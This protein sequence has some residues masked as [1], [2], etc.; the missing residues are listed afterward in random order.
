MLREAF[1]FTL[2]SSRGTTTNSESTESDSESSKGQLHNAAAFISEDQVNQNAVTFAAPTE[3][4]LK[5]L[6]P[7]C[8]AG[9]I[10]AECA[11]SF[12][13]NNLAVRMYFT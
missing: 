10:L 2:L 7:M 12:E 5:I 9:T 3:I 11:L 4:L 6:D 1:G 8:G 13:V